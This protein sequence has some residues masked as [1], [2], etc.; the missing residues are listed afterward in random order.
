MKDLEALSKRTGIP[1]AHFKEALGIPL[2]T[3]HAET[4]D[5]AQVAYRKAPHGSE[6]EKAALAKW[7]ALSMKELAAAKTVDEA[8][9]AYRNASHY[10][11]AEKAALVKWI[12]LCTT[13]AEAETAYVKAPSGSEAEKAALRKM[14][15]LF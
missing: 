6:T 15:D 11:E 12:E 1:V 8:Q 10:S 3:C 9:I 14:H 5:E 2:E 13:I 4:I 7:N